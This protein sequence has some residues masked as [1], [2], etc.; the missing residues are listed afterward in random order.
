M[1]KRTH[2]RTHGLV[3]AGELPL[4][5]KLSKE[6]APPTRAQLELIETGQRIR[7]EPGTIDNATYMHVVLCHLGMP[8][9][10]KKERVFERQYERPTFRY[11]LRIEA[12]VLW[13]GREFAEHPLPSGT[14]PRLVLLNLLTAAIRTKSR[15]IDAGHSQR[16]FMFRVGID[17]QGSEYKAFKKQM[18]AL[19]ACRMQ[20]GMT[21]PNGRLIHV[22]AQPVE[23]FETWLAPPS[24]TQQTLWPGQFTLSQQFY[25]GLADCLIPVDERAAYKLDGALEMDI[26]FWL[27]QRLCRVDDRGQ[28]ITWYALKDQF[29]PEYQR[30]RKFKEKFIASLKQVLA[31][32]PAAWGKVDWEK[33]VKALWLRYAPPPIPKTIVPKLPY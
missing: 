7:E 13:N 31:V 10:P 9:S 27:S 28:F 1:G 33:N 32:Y 26:Y 24:S 14:K 16:E 12:G 30:T 21:Y 23:K 29:A 6:F 17:P 11:A 3:R 22:N 19:A 4:L 15:F 5:N 18:H 8:R 25:D 2:Q 20:L